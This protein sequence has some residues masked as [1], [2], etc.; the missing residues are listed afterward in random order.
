MDLFRG[1]Q[2]YFFMAAGDWADNFAEALCSSA[3]QHGMLHEHSVQ[4]MLEGSFKSTSAEQD[5]GAA[6]VRVSL[7]IPPSEQKPGQ[8]VAQ[9]RAVSTRAESGQPGA[10][11]GQLGASQDSTRASPRQSGASPLQHQ[12]QDI[13]IRAVRIDNS[14]L[15]ALEAVRL[16]FEAAWP[17]SLVVTQVSLHD[18]PCSCCMQLILPIKLQTN[19]LLRLN[20]HLWL[21]AST[22]E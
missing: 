2:R 1:F 3:A 6:K 13:D 19:S 7:E 20:L 8:A 9:G 10:L 4:S 15:K 11:P 14:Q 21:K 5:S 12:G 16:S 22:L 18:K 17:L